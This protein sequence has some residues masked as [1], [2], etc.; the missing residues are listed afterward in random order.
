MKTIS[1][2]IRMKTITET[3]QSI[4]KSNIFGA[5]IQCGDSTYKTRYIKNR[6]RRQWLIGKHGME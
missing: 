3:I 1:Y 6:K 4:E 5:I 2:T